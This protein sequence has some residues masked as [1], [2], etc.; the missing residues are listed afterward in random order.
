MKY[1]KLKYE[2][3]G[4]IRPS[5]KGASLDTQRKALIAAGV[6]PQFI[7]EDWNIL[8]STTREGDI[9]GLYDLF[10][11]GTSNSMIVNR[12]GEVIDK[13]QTID[14][15]RE[16]EFWPERYQLKFFELFSR[17]V[18]GVGKDRIS[19]AQENRPKGGAHESWD[20]TKYR[21]AFDLWNES[22]DQKITVMR[23]AKLCR[24]TLPTFYI[25]AEKYL[26]RLSNGE[27]PHKEIPKKRLTYM[28]DRRGVKWDSETNK[29]KRTR[30]YYNKK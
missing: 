29:Y 30:S 15:I 12:W 1:E 13:G 6:N 8:Q 26:T 14:L 17:T 22:I 27:V 20:E 18:K 19:N 11:L 25:W 10:Y 9:I 24:V 4:F 23:A 21:Q 16:K 28:R 5:K 2:I 3:K 7:Y